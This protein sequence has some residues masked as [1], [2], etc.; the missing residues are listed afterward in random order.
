[1]DP[2]S[3]SISND[4]HHPP[5]F[6]PYPSY[7]PSNSFVSGAAPPPNHPYFVPPPNP[8]TNHV[9]QPQPQPQPPFQ[10]AQPP[11]QPS[12]NQSAYIEMICAA[13]AA[14]NEPDGSSKMAISRYIERTYP[15]LT[16]AHGA[17]LTHHLK[18]LKANGILTMVK[19]SYK[20]AVS[21]PPESVAVAAAAAAAGLEPPRSEIP[22]PFNNDRAPNDPVAVSGSGSASQP[23]KRG[24]GRPPKPKPEPQQQQA[25]DVQA[26]VVQ[27]NGQQSWEQQYQMALSV[28]Q[29]IS[30]SVSQPTGE[31]TES[32]KRGPGRPRKNG[33][34]PIVQGSGMAGIMKRRGRPPGRRAA[35]R[36]RKPNSVPQIL[37]VFPYGANG[38]RRRGRPRRVETSGNTTVAAAPAPAP[39]GGE[40]V[41]VAPGMKRGR[42]RPPKIGGVINRLITKPKR[43]RGRPVGR[44]RKF[45]AGPVTATQDPAYG[46]LKK[47]FDLFQ[48]K[49]KE[50]LNVLKAE[51]KSDN[52]AVV[53]AIQDLEGLTVVETVEPPQAMEEVQPEEAAPPTD[54]ETQGETGGEAQGETKGVEQ[55]QER[56][57]GAA[58]AQIQTEAEAMQEALF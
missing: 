31:V 56:E 49:A 7:S 48:E 20:L 37:S 17:L 57:E 47:K 6:T 55:G 11:S 2:P 5:Q 52:E 34:G 32:A 41:P 26:N 39:A 24:R 40:T 42:G 22:M 58:P 33:A 19:K 15:G 35:G 16:A 44:P 54:A 29:P 53:R 43:G 14:L 9:Y 21:S 30:V 46:E 1:M 36:Q 3:L 4:P 45:A 18:S 13:I 10:A 23:L 25:G 12:P 27:S 38:V 51:V 50:I 28:S 8:Y